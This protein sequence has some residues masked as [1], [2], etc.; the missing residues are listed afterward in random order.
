MTTGE[1]MAKGDN[2]RPIGWDEP[3]APPRA[4][5]GSGGP[6]RQ[7]SLRNLMIALVYF[8]LVFWVGRNLMETNAMIQ[9]VLLATL[10]G[11]GLAALGLWAALR[12]ERFASVGWIIFV[13]GTMVVMLATIHV[14]AVPMLPILIG[15][16]IYLSL[17]R[18]ATDQDALLRVMDLA[19]RRGIPLAPGV[20]AFS[21]QAN[22]VFRVWTAS[23]AEL[24]RQGIPLPDAIDNLPGVVHRKAALLIRMGQESGDLAS[25]LRAAIE[26]GPAG[27]PAVRAIVGRIGYLIGVLG[28]GFLIVAF[29]LYFVIPKYQM[30][31]KDFGVALPESTALVIRASERM[32]D[33]AWI[34][35]LVVLGF[36]IYLLYFI[37]RTPE[38]GLPLFDRLF[39]RRHAALILRSLAVVVAS[40]RPIVPALRAMSDWYPTAWVRKRLALAS[41]D[42]EQGVDWTESLGSSDLLSPGDIGVIGASGRAGNLPWA[43][44]ELAE[45]G[46]RRRAY[47]LQFWSQVLFVL[48]ILALGSVIYVIA[49]AWFQPLTHLILRLAQ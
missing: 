42:A 30:I 49:V 17:R 38:M 36:L 29:G 1:I 31:M 28:V 24:L 13:V 3:L 44:R 46:E 27:S 34:S 39:P 21:G 37:F 16:I 4:P 11:L 45:T 5:R 2:P 32:I 8:A 12:M 7:L 22:G 10:I 35:A 14:F 43:L 23:L 9:W 41:L 20:E 40:G 6:L 25:G 15:A 33:F 47:R 18:R 19:A 48:A 26:A